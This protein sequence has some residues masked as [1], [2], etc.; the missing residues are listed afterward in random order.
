[1]E[2]CRQVGIQCRKG[3]SWNGMKLRRN[4]LASCCSICGEE[5]QERSRENYYEGFPSPLDGIDK[6]LFVFQ[7]YLKNKNFILNLF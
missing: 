5:D 4:E 2:L 3:F 1:M 7:F 6:N